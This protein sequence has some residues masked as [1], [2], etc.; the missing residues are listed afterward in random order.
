MTRDEF[1]AYIDDF[2]S[3]DASRLASHFTPDI[4]FENYGGRESG[5]AVVA[6]LTWLTTVVETRMKPL[7]IFVDGD[8]IALEA[9]M[10]VVALAD[11]P[12]LPIGALKQGDRKVSRTFAFYDTTGPMIRHVRLAGWPP[13]DG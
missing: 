13:I 4:V 7:Q 10:H 6:F 2:N 9:D 5:E 3:G 12:H 1:L 8:R 11:L